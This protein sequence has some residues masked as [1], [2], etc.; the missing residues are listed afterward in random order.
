MKD[1]L[2]DQTLDHI[3]T[4]IRA[5]TDA[6]LKVQQKDGHWCFELEADCTIPSE[7][8]LMMHYLD[9]IDVD[10]ERKMAVYLRARQNEKVDGHY[11][12]WQSRS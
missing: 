4:A 1:I 5:A 10:L 6:L 12:W 11:I 9:E 7:Y 8:I 3:S 2:A